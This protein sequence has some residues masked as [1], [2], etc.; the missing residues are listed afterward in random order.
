MKT[1]FRMKLLSRDFC[2]L[3]SLTPVILQ[4][5][6]IYEKVD[7]QRAE[8]STVKRESTLHNL[9]PSKRLPKSPKNG[10]NVAEKRLRQWWYKSVNT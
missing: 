6:K 2:R 4:I 9:F 3:D 8:L 7:K 1:A 5:I 10:I